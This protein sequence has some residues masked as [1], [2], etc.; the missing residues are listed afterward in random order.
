MEQSLFSQLKAIGIDEELAA[1]VSNSLDPDYNASKKDV[2]V[3]QEAMMQ[4]QLQSERSYNNLLLEITNVRT[5][6]RSEIADVRAEVADVRAEV[7]DVGRSRRCP[8]R[9]RRCS[10]R[11]RRGQGRNGLHAP[12]VLDYLWRPYHHHPQCLWR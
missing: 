12:S 6:L 7:A 1:S 8:G 2:L 9:S 3:M 10:S 11:C 5:D 4:V